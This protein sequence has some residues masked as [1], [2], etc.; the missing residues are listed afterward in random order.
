M[1]FGTDGGQA[2]A[3][4]GFSLQ[5]NAKQA[6]QRLYHRRGGERLP[7]ARGGVFF[8]KI[9]DA[10]RVL[11]TVLYQ[12]QVCTRKVLAE[13]FDVT[14]TTIGIAC[15]RVGPLLGQDGYI[16]TPAPSLHKTATALLDSVTPQTTH[17]NQHN[18]RVD[19]LRLPGERNFL[20]ARSRCRV[21]WWEFSALLFRYF[22]RRCSTLGIS[23]RWA[24]P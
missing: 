12:R 13:L 21:G 24:T 19:F 18:R 1:R 11:I 23:R 7:G 9:T 17:R 10:E 6:E 20:I 8:E 16:P 2:A 5:A 4:A 14:P 3:G 15:R 22:D